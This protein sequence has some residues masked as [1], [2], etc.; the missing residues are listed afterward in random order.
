M[1]FPFPTLRQS[2]KFEELCYLLYH[3][4]NFGNSTTNR[5]W[6]VGRTAI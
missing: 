6:R 3:K 4:K 5:V 2:M 1:S